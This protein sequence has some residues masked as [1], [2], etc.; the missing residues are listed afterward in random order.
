MDIDLLL[1]IAH[2]LSVFALV[3]LYAAE[4][5]L[6]RPGLSGARIRQLAQI[7]A[8]YGGVAGLVIVVGIIRVIFGVR[9]WE[10]YVTNH[11]FWGKMAAL[12]VVGLLT[13]QPTMAIRKWLKAV[14]TDESYVPPPAE[15]A[16]SR[17]LVHI[18]AGVLL[19]IPIFAA[20]MARGYGS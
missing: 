18:Q 8:A 4:F 2:H 11:A 6:L 20:A 9:G 10:Y 17:R 3:A 19:L 14:G 13:I 15:I 7:D 5:A 1:A 12:L 16:T